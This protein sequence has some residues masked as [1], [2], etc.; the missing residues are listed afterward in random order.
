MKDTEKRLGWLQALR[1]IAAISV[2]ICHC[3]IILPKMPPYLGI[4]AV[5]DQFG[6]GV[7]LFFVISGFIMVHVTQGEAGGLRSAVRFVFRR[8]QRI[9]PPYFVLTLAIGFSSF[10]WHLVGDG[11]TRLRLIKSIL[12]VP[13]NYDTIYAD[14]I[15]AQGWTLGFEVYFYGIFA[16]SL[17][18]AKARWVF[19]AACWSVTLFAVPLAYH[20]SL[21]DVFQS[22]TVDYPVKYLKLAT[23][24][25][26]WE[27]VAGG[28]V[29]LIYQS[30]LRIESVALCSALAPTAVGF[31]IWNTFNP[32]VPGSLG[33][34]LPFAM[35][36]G[37]VALASKTVEIRTSQVLRYLGD[38][39]YTLYL[40]HLAIIYALQFLYGFLGVRSPLSTFASV[41]ITIAVC[42]LA[43]ALSS[44]F[45]E[46]DLPRFLLKV[47]SGIHILTAMPSLQRDR[48]RPESS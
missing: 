22:Y 26:I 21:A 7:D 8:L 19:L 40:E 38:I 10:G 29:G 24:P 11:E 27:F 32:L 41:P 25:F 3:L 4:A 33:V 23:N 16:A 12:F 44:R 14:Q 34:G 9:W 5:F 18:F 37:A 31:A 43:A 20:A 17:L 47:I 35:M 6:A 30:A 1:G 46:H 28:V 45:L 13:A 42:I 15:I 2:V 48:L 36:I 39:S